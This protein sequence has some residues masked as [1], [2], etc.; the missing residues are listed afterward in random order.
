MRILFLSNSPKQTVVTVRI[1]GDINKPAE[2]QTH[3][4]NHDSGHTELWNT[5]YTFEE[6]AYMHKQLCMKC[7]IT[8]NM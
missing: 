4:Y 2:Y 5:S 3:L 6:G 7:Y 1:D 8:T